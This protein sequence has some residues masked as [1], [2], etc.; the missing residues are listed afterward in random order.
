MPRP[1]DGIALAL[2]VGCQAGEFVH[3]IGDAHVYKNHVEPLRE[4][5][6]RCAL[7]RGPLPLLVVVLARATAVPVTLFAVCRQLSSFLAH[8][9][10]RQDGICPS[11]LLCHFL[12]AVAVRRSPRPF[13][14]LTIDPTIKDIDAFRSVNRNLARARRSPH[15]HRSSR[16]RRSSRIAL[17]IAF[18]CNLSGLR[19]SRQCW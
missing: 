1:C 11:F 19:P 14:K 17:R 2:T 16:V 10:T 13:P 12:V 3:I 15:P 18:A 9:T 4:Q 6:S 8:V 5:L 7:P